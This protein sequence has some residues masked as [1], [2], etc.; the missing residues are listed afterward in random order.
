MSGGTGSCGCREGAAYPLI[1]EIRLELIGGCR[2]GERQDERGTGDASL[3]HFAFRL[4]RDEVAPGS[5]T[6][7]STVHPGNVGC[8]IFCGI[9]V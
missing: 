6:G 5:V 8:Y 9:M 2:F 1:R 7:G 4:E 3:Y